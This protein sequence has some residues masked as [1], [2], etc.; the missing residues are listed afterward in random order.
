MHR[1]LLK[2]VH[3][4]LSYLRNNM[5]AFWITVYTEILDY[6]RED[7]LAT[8]KFLWDTICCLDIISNFIFRRF[9]LKMHIHAL[10]MFFGDLTH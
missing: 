8:H 4:D 6:P 2:S 3:F 7:C 9:D 10:K 5:V 1:K